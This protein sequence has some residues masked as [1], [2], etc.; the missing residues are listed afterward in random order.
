MIR[1]GTWPVRSRGFSLLEVLVAFS[2]LAVSLGTLLLVF[3]GGLRNTAVSR[4]YS[5]A[6][7]YAE[8]K[9]AE[10]GVVE[11]LEVGEQEGN[12]DDRYRWEVEI[13]P[14]TVVEASERASVKPYHVT[15]KVTWGEDN[16]QRSV[17]LNTLRL[18]S[19]SS[20]GLQP[21][22]NT[23]IDVRAAPF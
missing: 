18:A 14:Y 10:I 12:F 4:D 1:S 16:R 2:I 22:N 9:L 17:V 19:A 20:A 8:S 6:I 23:G 15:V 13:T 11:P 5:R 3:S 21:L 7:A